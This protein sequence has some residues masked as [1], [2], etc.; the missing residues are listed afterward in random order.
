ME[1]LIKGLLQH[2]SD[3]C[4]TL[5]VPMHRVHERTVDALIMKKALIQAKETLINKY[6]NTE[7]ITGILNKLAQ[8]VHAVDFTQAK[9]GLG[10]YISNE[11]AEVI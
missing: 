8:K 3:I 6:G 5:V 11:K 2:Q 4:L 7:A 10:I 9:D 1:Q